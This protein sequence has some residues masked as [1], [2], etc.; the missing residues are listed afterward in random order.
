[1]TTDTVWMR[2]ALRMARRALGHT[3]PNPLVGALV[4]KDGAL[5]GQG[6]HHGPGTPHAEV[7]A[8]D[9][10][11]D[12][13]RGATLYV[14]LEP[15]CHTDKRT[16]PCV[17]MVIASGVS[18]VVIAMVD[19][20]PKV[21]GGGIRALRAATGIEVKVGVEEAAA[22]ALNAPFI[23]TMETGLPWVTLKLAQTL[24]GKVATA[25]GAS[26]WITGAAARRH[27]HRMRDRHDAIVVG[28]GTVLADDPQLTCRLPAGRNPLRV[29]VDAALAAPGTA[30]VLCAD[31][32]RATLIASITASDPKRRTALD[33]AGAEVLALPE[34]ERGRV[35]LKALL[36]A[37][38]GRGI[39]RVLC[40]GGPTLSAALL[41]AGLVN[42]VACFLAPTL[43]GGDTSRGSIGGFSPTALSGAYPLGPFSVRR[44]GPDLLLE[45]DVLTASERRTG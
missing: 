29:V 14:T 18:R 1:V 8:L 43:M 20:N 28:I 12:Q 26:K 6:Y 22:R 30:R 27:G 4:I 34:L 39:Q 17:P 24:D 40:E 45:A 35:D 38:A 19:P 15:C 16:P 42:R 36:M 7:H 5:V 10:A 44:F 13:A 32:D 37:L 33:S 3:S 21:A 2:Q 11:G 25:N 23:R 31:D 41:D 9:R